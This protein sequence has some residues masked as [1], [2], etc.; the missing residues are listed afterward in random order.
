LEPGELELTEQQIRQ[1]ADLLKTNF[2]TG[3]EYFIGT[4]FSAQ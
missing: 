4:R 2:P 3:L 1:V